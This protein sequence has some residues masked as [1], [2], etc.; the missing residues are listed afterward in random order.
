MTEAKCKQYNDSRQNFQ[1][2]KEINLDKITVNKMPI[3]KM[4]IS[5]M[6]VNKISDEKNRKVSDCR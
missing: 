4:T 2:K 3:D 1:T 5:K 6:T